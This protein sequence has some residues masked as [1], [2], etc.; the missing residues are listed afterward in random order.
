M[1]C[2]T[3]QRRVATLLALPAVRDALAAQEKL[4]RVRALRSR[5]RFALDGP[6]SRELRLIAADLDRTLDGES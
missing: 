1:N 3:C 4:R 6:A 2:R 5:I